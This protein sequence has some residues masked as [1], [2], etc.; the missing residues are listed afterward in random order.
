MIIQKRY[1]EKYAH[2]PRTKILL[3]INFD[4]DT[5]R[6]DDFVVANF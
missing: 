1:A 3:G 4:T 6:A 2:D 5:R